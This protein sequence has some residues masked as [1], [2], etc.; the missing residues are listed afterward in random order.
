MCNPIF[1]TIRAARIAFA[2]TVKINSE[3]STQVTPEM[4][5]PIFN[6]WDKFNLSLEYKIP[7]KDS[8]GKLHYHG[9]VY[10]PK[11]FYRKKMLIK[12]HNGK[13][14]HLKLVELFD[15]KGW[16]KYIHK[17]CEFHS[18][19]QQANEEMIEIPEEDNRIFTKRLFLN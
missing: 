3:N 4:Y 11:G 18:L 13:N 9:I 1:D 15:K 19:E 17:D 7:E 5:S 16:E 14:Y 12:D 6:R 2:F 10:V 8:K